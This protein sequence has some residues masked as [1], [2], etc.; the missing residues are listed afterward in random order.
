MISSGA[1]CLFHLVIV[2]QFLVYQCFL[3]TNYVCLQ[4]TKSSSDDGCFVG[5]SA[6]R[7]PY[8]FVTYFNSLDVIEIQGHA[9][10]G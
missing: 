7:E 6:Y 1:V 3:L 9:A 8:L 2:T 10:L 4:R 5:F